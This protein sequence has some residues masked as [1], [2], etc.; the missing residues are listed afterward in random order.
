MPHWT[1]ELF[2][3]HPELLLN[4]FAER[5]EGVPAEV[6]ILLGQLKEGGFQP[7]RLTRVINLDHRIWSLHELIS[8][9]GRAGWK[10]EAVH[11]G[12][13]AGFSF[14]KIASQSVDNILQNPMLLTIYRRI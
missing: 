8:L 14:P 11:P 9:F 13:S 3:E 4:F 6:D 2:E 10:Y 7:E 12:F 1:E 5:M